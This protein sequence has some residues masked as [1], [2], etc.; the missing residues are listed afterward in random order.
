[1]L[2]FGRQFAVQDPARWLRRALAEM[3]RV[4]RPGGRVVILVPPPVPRGLT[5]LTL[6]SSYPLRLLGVS[7]RIWVFDRRQIPE[8]NRAEHSEDAAAMHR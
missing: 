6:A 4:T 8:G 5:E 2:P 3:G 1:N 7:T